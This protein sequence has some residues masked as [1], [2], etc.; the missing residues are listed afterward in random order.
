[1]HLARE[2][3][4][5]DSD[6]QKNRQELFLAFGKDMMGVSK[7]DQRLGQRWT[8]STDCMELLG[9]NSREHGPILD[10][11]SRLNTPS[12]GGHR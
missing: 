3:R 9:A 6:I 4:S 11:V 8:K 12:S 2:A 7:E 5:S 1:M 10:T